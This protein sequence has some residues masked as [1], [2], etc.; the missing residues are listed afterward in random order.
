MLRFF[1]IND[2]FRL[3]GI[4]IILVILSGTYFWILDVP[5]LQPE[6]IWMLAGE[7]LA[8]GNHMYKDV[9]DDTGPLSA[10]VY[11][12][13]H[14]IFGKSLTAL[15]L[16]AALVILFQVTYINSLFIRYKSFEENTYIPAA[17]MVVL[18][19]LSYDFLTLSPALMGST[20]I[21]L[22]LG[23]L[24][25]QTVLQKE[26]SDSVLLVGV[27]GGI[28]ACFHFPLVVFLPFLV[29]S[30]VIV[31]G[32][33]F[34]QFVLALVGYF[35]PIVLVGLYYFWID[36]L[37]DFIFE[38]FFA[39]R[40]LEV[41]QHIS[42][43]DTGLLFA[44]PVALAL[45]GYFVGL[46]FKLITVNQQKQRQLIFIFLLF[47]ISS[48]FLTNRR[49]PYQWII[50]LPALTYFINQIFIYL[51]QK[52]VLQ[53]F[54]ILFFL[55][56]PLVGYGWFIFQNSA[57]NFD[58]Y[59]IVYQEKHQI[60]RGKKI[61]V[62]GDDI[63]YYKEASLGASYLNSKLSNR[64]LKDFDDFADMAAVYQEFFTEKPDLIIDQEGVFA[65]LTDRVPLLNNLYQEEANGI[66]LLK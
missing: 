8:D 18:F 24:F 51:T 57:G 36:A 58:S 42:I 37:P 5:M 65:G 44:L 56:I 29:V 11:W 40:I 13:I 33:T 10:G 2:P 27:F 45:I 15:R 49:T 28:A 23:Q 55:G 7:R 61:L 6:L 47:A 53:I 35:L 50:L 38:Y 59:A 3:I 16:L 54:V 9:V 19:H 30:G 41:Y 63:A 25:S 21:L 60:A 43:E 17:I 22:A 48:V 4:L 39:T 46:W 64:I 20:F 52:R 34:N 62:L 12:I 32:F 31:S 1:R 26:G 14:L 66:Y